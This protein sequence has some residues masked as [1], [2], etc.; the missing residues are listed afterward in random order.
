MQ[1][2]RKLHRKRAAEYTRKYNSSEKGRKKRKE[3]RSKYRKTLRGA[4][5]KRLDKL[6][7]KYRGRVKI[8]LDEFC[9]KFDGVCA[10]CGGMLNERV[11]VRLNNSVDIITINDIDFVHTKCAGRKVFDK[12]C[13]VCGKKYRTKGRRSKYCNSCAKEKK[14]ENMRER[15]KRNKKLCIKSNKCLICGKERYKHYG[16]C[17]ECYNT[18]CRIKY[19][20]KRKIILYVH[21][22]KYC[23]KKYYNRIKKSC[24][25]KNNSCKKR[26]NREFYVK[27]NAE[28]RKKKYMV[29]KEYR[30]EIIYNG[31][32]DRCNNKNSTLYKKY[33]MKGIKLMIY[34]ERFI[35]IYV[36]AKRCHLCG[37]KFKACDPKRCQTT[38]RANNDDDYTEKNIQFLCNKCN[39]SKG[40]G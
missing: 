36:A 32:F 16:L 8:T 22:C 21:R 40:G 33:G 20:K 35:D 31:I 15:R 10:S 37:C 2:K 13:E 25:C 4:L 17:K 24:C 11:G 26:Y 9:D 3:W 1:K 39:S 29:D 23:E 5:C 28:K 6:R 12:I 27:N 38:D 30:A 19:Y 34:K 18:K 14:K 7:Q